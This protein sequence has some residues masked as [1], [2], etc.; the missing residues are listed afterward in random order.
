[1]IIHVQN[2][3]KIEYANIDIS[4]FSIFVGENNSGKSYMMQLIYG[5]I[6]C[7]FYDNKFKRYLS[8]FKLDISEKPTEI[9]ATDELFLSKFQNYI[10]AFLRIEKERIIRNN[11]HTENL[12]IEELSIELMP[13]EYGYTLTMGKSPI[14][15]SE[16]DISIICKF[17]RSD[18]KV[19]GIRFNRAFPKELINYFVCQQFLSLILSDMVGITLNNQRIEDMSIIYLPASRSGIMLL[20]ANY[21]AND[22]KEKLKKHSNINSGIIYEDDNEDESTSE[23]E[24]GLTEPVYN[25]LMFLLK[26]KDSELLSESNRNILSFIN[27]NIINGKLTKIGNSMVYQ[28][29]D[30]QESIPIYLSSSLVSELAPIC[31]VISG[32]THPNI[33]LYDEIE[34]CQHP[35]KQLQLSRLL[36]RMVNAGYKMIVSTH[37]DTM[38]AAIN[39]LI[40]LSLKKNKYSLASKLGYNEDDILEKTNVHA[41]Q[42]IVNNGKTT[43]EE[44]PNYFSLGIGFDFTL[45]N[46]TNDQIYQDAVCLAEEE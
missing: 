19:Q 11:F 2:F 13:L 27:E 36:I 1:M 32:I 21:L 43:V 22:N 28:P 31:Q 20:Y 14:V 45:F 5:V 30:S 25:F 29:K 26:H 9:N 18:G 40:T 35:T 10:N 15:E 17:T 8:E 44:I 6:S 34:T 39:N 42:F 38:A 24:Y 46:K 4:N 23:N 16:K 7:L 37:S 41:Y 3:G 33:I 12:S